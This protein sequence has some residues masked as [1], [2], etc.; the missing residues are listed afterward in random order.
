MNGF[1]ADGGLREKGVQRG[2]DGFLLSLQVG[3]QIGHGSLL[4]KL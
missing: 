1:R 2:I 4:N 3:F